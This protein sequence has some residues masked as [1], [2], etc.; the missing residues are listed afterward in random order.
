[1]QKLGENLGFV[2]TKFKFVSLGQG[3]G[4]H[5]AAMIETGYQRGHWVLLQNCHLLTS[6]L[7]SLEKILEGTT[8]SSK[9]LVKAA[10]EGKRKIH[11]RYIL[12]IPFGCNYVERAFCVF[13]VAS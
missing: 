7:K 4:P 3:M 12:Q 2:G 10:I 1:M 13:R 9:A 11:K 5:A 6:W 8:Y